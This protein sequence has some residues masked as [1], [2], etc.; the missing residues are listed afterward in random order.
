MID[1]PYPET[2]DLCHAI[3]YKILIG[4]GLSQSDQP[5]SGLPG[6]MEALWKL[7]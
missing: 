3:A 7:I 2:I 6:N 4:S 1:S 5:G